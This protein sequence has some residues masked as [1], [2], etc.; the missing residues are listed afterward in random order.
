[1]A[2]SVPAEC[3]DLSRQQLELDI[4]LKRAELASRQADNELRREDHALKLREAR[5]SN[6]RNPLVVAVLAAAVAATG[7]AVVAYL[8]NSNLQQ[9]EERKGQSSLILEA[10]KTGDPDKASVNLQLLLDAGLISDSR[11]DAIR[12]YLRNRR[13]GTGAAL[14]STTGR[15]RIEG[16]ERLPETARAALGQQLS[17]FAAHLDQLGLRG[18]AAQV[19]VVIDPAIETNSYFDSE[20][21]S[22][23]VA[24]NVASDPFSTLW[25]YGQYVVPR[26]VAE[27]AS[28]N[29]E[30]AGLVSGLIDYLTASFMDQPQIGAGIAAVIDAPDPYIR[31][32]ENR[33][34]YPTVL[35]AGAD[36]HKLGE[37]WGGAFWEIRSRVGRAVA[38]RTIA[39]AWLMSRRSDRDAILGDFRRSLIALA[40]QSG[41]ER[42]AVFESVLRARG[43]HPART[44]PATRQ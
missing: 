25:A 8:N 1:M 11:A 9:V 23:R 32:L 7:N 26:G 28:E 27:G 42:A 39:R 41:E 43:L 15:F 20:T 31:N 37:A 18:E 29:R 36:Q 30:A 13:P 35:A 16:S 3:S 38:D 19:R 22:V 40:R 12:A 33:L 34:S 5:A 14:P 21:D 17:A 6:W 4:E 2:S 24:A 10:I 44:G